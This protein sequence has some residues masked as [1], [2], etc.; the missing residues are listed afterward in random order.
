MPQL[1]KKSTGFQVATQ[2]IGTGSS[3][4]DGALVVFPDLNEHDNLKELVLLKKIKFSL[5]LA[6]LPNMTEVY[7][8]SLIAGI[9]SGNYFPTP[10]AAW[11]IDGH[12]EKWLSKRS[13][14]IIQVDTTTSL[15]AKLMEIEMDFSDD[16][17]AINPFGF[18]AAVGS[19]GVG[20]FGDDN[21]IVEYHYQWVKANADTQQAY[22]RWELLGV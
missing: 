8:G 9:R 15:G 18:S 22:L 12:L 19:D 5:Y 3:T 1:I 4:G 11:C 6:A 10:P 17:L 21:F 16:P 14:Y 13:D 7:S 2:V 20:V